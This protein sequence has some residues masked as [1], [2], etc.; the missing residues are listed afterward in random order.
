MKKFEKISI[1]YRIYLTKAKITKRNKKI[2]IG[3]HFFIQ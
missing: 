3:V 2:K 1:K